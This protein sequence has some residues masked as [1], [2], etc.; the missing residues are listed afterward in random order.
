LLL[1]WLRL[2]DQFSQSVLVIDGI[3][4]ILKKKIGNLKISNNIH[5]GRYETAEQL[6]KKGQFL[7]VKFIFI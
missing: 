5:K 1:H 7:N 2:Q 4:A 6:Q 3:L